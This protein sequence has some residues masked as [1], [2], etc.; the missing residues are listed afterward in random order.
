M[1]THCQWKQ[2][3]GR[4]QLG[5]P[6]ALGPTADTRATPALR[7]AVGER[8]A[9]SLCSNWRQTATTQGEG[10]LPR[11]GPLPPGLGQ[12]VVPVAASAVATAPG[13]RNPEPSPL[14]LHRPF[15]LQ[16]C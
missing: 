9:A 2:P 10:L 1:I 12:V 11:E 5:S 8:Q 14:N 15:K 13:G 16:P 3:G 7:Q 6:P 4:W